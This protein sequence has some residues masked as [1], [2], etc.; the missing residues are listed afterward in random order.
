MRVRFLIRTMSLPVPAK[1]L[2]DGTQLMHT[3][4]RFPIL[5][6]TGYPRS[7]LEAPFPRCGRAFERRRSLAGLLLVNAAGIRDDAKALCASQA[8]LD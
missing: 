2:A 4:R 3:R 1:A 8:Y 7:L 5:N 6:S